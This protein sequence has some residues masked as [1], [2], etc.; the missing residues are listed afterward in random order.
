MPKL[1]CK[2][3]ETLENYLKAQRTILVR[4]M[5]TW[6]F[7]GSTSDGA[8]KFAKSLTPYIQ[9]STPYDS[10]FIEMWEAH[11]PKGKEKI[12]VITQQLYISTFWK[13]WEAEVCGS[14][15]VD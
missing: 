7:V 12:T 9:S 1:F 15:A 4:K 13:D 3:F 5:Q 11:I 6:E 10:V 8:W 14:L 2:Y